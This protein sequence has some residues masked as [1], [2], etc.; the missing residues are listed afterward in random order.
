MKHRNIEIDRIV[1]SPKNLK[2]DANQESKAANYDNFHSG[3]IQEIL[4]GALKRS[5]AAL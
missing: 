3:N 4:S 1:K 5:S 2:R